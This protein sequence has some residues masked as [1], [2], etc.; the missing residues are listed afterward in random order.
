VGGTILNANFLAL[1]AFAL[2]YGLSAYWSKRR[3]GVPIAPAMAHTAKYTAGLV[4]LA[5]LYAFALNALQ[6]RWNSF[7]GYG[8]GLLLG[9]VGLAL[10]LAF[11]TMQ[12]RQGRLR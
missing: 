2:I 1:V 6:V 12:R 11:Q 7:A 10:F 9:L 8:L 5:V 4:V 3:A